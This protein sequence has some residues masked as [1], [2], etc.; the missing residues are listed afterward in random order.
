MLERLENIFLRIWRLR[1]MYG[2][3]VQS[4]SAYS[5]IRNIVNE[6]YP[7][8]DYSDLKAQFPHAA[9][10]SR[11]LGELYFRIANAYQPKTWFS[12]LPSSDIYSS[13]IHSGCQQT[14]IVHIDTK[15]DQNLPDQLNHFDLAYVNLI[16]EGIP[17]GEKLLHLADQHS[18]LI[19][20]QIHSNKQN[21]H[22]WRQVIA[23]PLTCLTFDLYYCGI[24]FFDRTKSKQNFIVNF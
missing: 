3:G 17:V 5:F 4:P 1:H 10:L 7:Y 18:I 16:Q 2:F 21:R 6:K 15:S 11:K 9:Y 20:E 23:S 13:Y 12:Y 8:Y 14:V 19:L 24:I 22:F